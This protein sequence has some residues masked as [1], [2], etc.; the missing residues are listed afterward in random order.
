MAN[1][2]VLTKDKNNKI[3]HYVVREDEAKQ[4]PIGKN[5]V[6]GEKVIAVQEIK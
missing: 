5:F 6:T 4:M 1:M 3:R 2:M